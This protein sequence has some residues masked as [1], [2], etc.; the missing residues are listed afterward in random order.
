M[1]WIELPDDI[2]LFHA[3]IRGDDELNT[4]IKRS[5]LDIFSHYRENGVVKLDGYDSDPEQADEELVTVIKNTIAD[6][7]SF[8]LR[9]YNAEYGVESQRQ[10]NRTISFRN[11]IYYTEF[12]RHWNS[13]LTDFDS[14]T[15]LFYV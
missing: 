13:L 2:D 9:G 1:K 3:S 8:R 6:I 15:A 10:G 5:E 12:P 11:S 7:V 14:R 4:A